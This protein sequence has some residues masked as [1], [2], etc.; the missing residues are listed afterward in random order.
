MIA[1]TY[2]DSNLRGK[3]D[4][5]LNSIKIMFEK[6]VSHVFSPIF[7]V[8]GLGVSNPC[9]SCTCNRSIAVI[10]PTVHDLREL[11]CRIFN[12]MSVSITYDNWTMTMCCSVCF[13]PD[14]SQ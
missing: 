10:Q 5:D 13:A 1:V 12:I 8:N 2:A 9:F 6:N 14:K 11:K 7:V 4:F 3:I